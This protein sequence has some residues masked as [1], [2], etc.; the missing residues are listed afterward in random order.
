MRRASTLPA[1]TTVALRP[2]SAGERIAAIA[3]PG[4]VAPVDAASSAPRPSQHLARWGIR[5]QDD[6]GVV[7]ARAAIAAFPVLVAAQ[8]ERFLYGSAGANHADALRALLERA[9]EERPAAVI[10][11]A[12]SGG[13]R[14]HEANPAELACARALAALVDLRAAGVPVV[15]LGVGDV[16]GG[17]SI[18][19]CAADRVALLPGT[20]LGLTGPGLID[21]AQGSAAFDAGDPAAVAGLFGAHARAAAGVVALVADDAEAVRA[22][23]LSAMHA[24]GSFEERVD[25]MHARLAARQRGGEP[26]V[27][28]HAP[29]VIPLPRAL[30]SL[31]SEAEPVD[32]TGWLWRLRHRPIFL[33]RPFG[34][35]KFGPREAHALDAALL[36]H[37]APRAASD[38]FAVFIVGDSFGHEATAV[39]ESLCVSQYLAQHAVVLGLLRARGVRLFGLLTGTGHSAAFFANALQAP[40]V[41]ALPGA[42][43]VAMAP[44]AIARVTRVDAAQVA[45]RIEDDPLVGHPVRHFA[46]W[47]GIAGILP[48][49]SPERL[50]ALVE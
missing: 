24:S 34:L 9:R 38:R 7:L 28:S 42:R 30:A 50:L 4:S 11:L 20:K 36:A 29:P 26:A 3:D 23:I 41:F 40:R 48:D 5:A 16:F 25:A 44:A 13:V 18:I 15:A 47:G 17:A 35:G 39:A 10:L 27:D 32:G 8:D 49:A 6:D 1:T 19:A 33:T 21:A 37:V 43:V 22:W 12:A 46:A 31:F 14:L 45:A 2:L